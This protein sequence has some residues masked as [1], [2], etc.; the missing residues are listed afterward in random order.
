MLI[1]INISNQ[2]NDYILRIIILF[3]I[4]NILT[5]HFVFRVNTFA[6]L[7]VVNKIYIL[8]TSSVSIKIMCT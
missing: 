2:H 7:N 6:K 8:F 1:Y 3:I 5:L 4:T